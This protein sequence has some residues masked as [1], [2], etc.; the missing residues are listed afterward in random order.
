M[1]DHGALETIL[2]G[3]REDELQE[4]AWALGC[5][6]VVADQV[7]QMVS[8]MKKLLVKIL[9]SKMLWVRELQVEQCRW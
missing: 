6:V 4:V 5:L 8:S 1:W 3:A 9:L 7:V 2:G